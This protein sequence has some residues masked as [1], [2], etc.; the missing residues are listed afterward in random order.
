MNDDSMKKINPELEAPE[1]L[2]EQKEAGGK[3]PKPENDIETYPLRQSSDDP[4]WAVRVV[5][6]WMGFVI[7]ALIFILTLLVFGA[8][9]D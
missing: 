8:I 2:E 1:E 7:A 3:E 4:R 9:Y 5:K 6:I